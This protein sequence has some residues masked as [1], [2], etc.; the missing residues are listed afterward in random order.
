LLEQPG[1]FAR[2]QSTYAMS[3]PVTPHLYVTTVLRNLPPEAQRLKRVQSRVLSD[4]SIGCAFEDYF[5]DRQRLAA[6][7]IL[8]ALSRRPSW[9]RN[10]GVASVLMRSLPKLL[11]G[12]HTAA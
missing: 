4:V 5:A 7:R 1:D 12:E 6:R 10:R 8:S 3:L 9:I 2:I 11:I